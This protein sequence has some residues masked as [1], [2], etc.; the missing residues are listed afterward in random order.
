VLTN[1]RNLEGYG[2][3]LYVSNST[4]TAGLNS[5]I[6]TVGS[7]YPV[8]SGNILSN[9]PGLDN[10]S[11]GS[12]ASPYGFVF[13]QL[14]LASPGFD[15]AYVADDGATTPALAGGIEKYSL[16]DG[17]WVLNNTIGL[18]TD[19]YRGLTGVAAANGFQLYATRQGTNP[20]IVPLLDTSGY[21]SNDNGTPSLIVA[22]PTNEAFRGI[23]F[24]PAAISTPEPSS[25]VL[26]TLAL[27]GL[28]WAARRRGAA[29][30]SIVSTP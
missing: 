5:G 12:N 11:G 23:D 19:S 2:N 7:G 28:L 22:L 25:M 14:N 1:V 17:A 18:S 16:V 10:N 6:N 21:N 9:I 26:S 29:H 27:V 13:A 30:G 4:T 24:A 3:Q 8:S 15:T 20:G